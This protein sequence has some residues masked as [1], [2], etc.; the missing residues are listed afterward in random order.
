MN[1]ALFCNFFVQALLLKQVL[2][3]AISDKHEPTIKLAKQGVEVVEV[4]NYFKALKER[5]N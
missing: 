1:T 5:G 3:G 2:Q 4:A